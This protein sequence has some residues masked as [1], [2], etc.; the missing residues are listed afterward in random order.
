MRRAQYLCKNQCA[1]RRCSIQ[2]V[3][4]RHARSLVGFFLSLPLPPLH[5][6]SSASF[7]TLLSPL[8]FGIHVL[9]PRVRARFLL[10]RVR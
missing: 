7:F 2:S 1:K 9:N 6:D 5:L 8:T 3:D 4:R 10:T